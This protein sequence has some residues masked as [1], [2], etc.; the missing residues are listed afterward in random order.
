MLVDAPADSYPWWNII[1]LIQPWFEGCS[2]E[3]FSIKGFRRVYFEAA[4]L[5]GL[6]SMLR[7]H[8]IIIR[9]ILIPCYSLG[10]MLCSSRVSFVTLYYILLCLWR[11]L[12]FFLIPGM[13]H[14]CISPIQ[15][16]LAITMHSIQSLLLVL[17]H[18][19]LIPEV[20]LKHHKPIQG[21]VQQLLRILCLHLGYSLIPGSLSGRIIQISNLIY[22]VLAYTQ[23]GGNEGYRYTEQCRKTLSRIKKQRTTKM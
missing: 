10:K 22:A 7:P 16:N 1:H 12:D 15:Q 9:Q 14:Q 2:I 3:G 4:W 8:V 5:M 20:Y 19:S 23:P 21:L 6:C 11:S 13:S 18:I 17:L